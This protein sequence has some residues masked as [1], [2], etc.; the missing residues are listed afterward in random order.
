MNQEITRT[1]AAKV[2]EMSRSFPCVMVTGARQVGKS[3][4]LKG[5][6][7]AGMKYITLDDERALGRA[8]EDP[9]GFLEECGRPLCI[10][11]VQYEPRL[12]RAIKLKVDETGEPGQYWL[13]GSQ[14]F[15]LMK[16]VSESLAGR[17]GIVELYSLSQS[18]VAG[19]GSSAEP[20]YPGEIRNRL[21]APACEITELY[22]RIWRGGYPRLFRYA[23]TSQE[24]YFSAYL[25]TYITRD[26]R[27]LTQVG[28]TAAFMRFMRSVAARSGQQLVFADIARDA[29]VSPNTAKNWLSVLE[30]SGVVDILQ[31]YYVNTSKRLAKS[32]KVYFADTGF[33][34][35]LGGW[36]TPR[37]LM[38]GA[39]AGAI[40]E[41]WAYGQL[42]RSFAN[43]GI[44]PRL[45]YYRSGNGAEVDFVLEMNGKLYPIEVKRSSS[46]KLGDLRAA[47]TMP[48]APGMELQSGIVLC[49]ATE[50]LPLGKGN[51]AYPISML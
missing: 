31:P 26:V 35:W 20:F 25:H 51:Y 42:R 34:A 24:D 2:L 30:T 47:D 43:R 49:T 10:D 39:M 23:E 11:E 32:S 7:P 36:D 19:K 28:D 33:C 17:V 9:I 29:E 18:E 3:T 5:M 21:G 48:L 14:R 1:M 6:L 22:E 46:P 41:T 15:H 44:R 4:L 12:L 45:S 38:Y 40:L 27:A 8:Q 50:I 37:S 13:T 16:G